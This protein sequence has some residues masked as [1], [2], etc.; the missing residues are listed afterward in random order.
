ME[1]MRTWT[2]TC[3]YIFCHFSLASLQSAAIHP[4][5]TFYPSHPL[6]TLPLIHM[7]AQAESHVLSD[8]YESYKCI[9]SPRQRFCLFFVLIRFVID[10]IPFDMQRKVNAWYTILFLYNFPLVVRCSSADM[11]CTFVETL[12]QRICV[13]FA[14]IQFSCKRIL[15]AN[16]RAMVCV[17]VCTWVCA[18]A[19]ALAREFSVWF[20]VYFECV[21]KE[22]MLI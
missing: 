8:T 11:W 17:C 7:V 16:V 22:A 21:H 15:S 3:H 19:R 1:C 6:P 5:P 14:Q 18:C 20:Y 9:K 2:W 10:C 4:S 12:S 13:L